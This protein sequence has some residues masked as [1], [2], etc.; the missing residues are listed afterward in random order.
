MLKEDA[1]IA[2]AV[3]ATYLTNDF[4]YSLRIATTDFSC[5]TNT[6]LFEGNILRFRALSSLKLF[7]H[8]LEELEEDKEEESRY[9]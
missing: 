7:E 6:P 9:L 1:F 2:Y 8:S 5:M 4:E 3:A